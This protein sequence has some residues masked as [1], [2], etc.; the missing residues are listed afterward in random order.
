MISLRCAAHGERGR[1]S[2]HRTVGARATSTFVINDVHLDLVRSLA[3]R[4]DGGTGGPDVVLALLRS[5][6]LCLVP[7]GGEDPFGGPRAR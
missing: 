6:V 5:I 2:R 4:E 3:G 7:V 1:P